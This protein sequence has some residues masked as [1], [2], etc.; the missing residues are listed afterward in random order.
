MSK[1]RRIPFLDVKGLTEDER[2]KLLGQKVIQEGLTV[3]FVVE[4]NA[5]ADRYMAKLKVIFPAI[6]EEARFKMTAD[7]ICVRVKS[8]LAKN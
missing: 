3:G 2:I 4:D 8:S 7:T 6:V 5:K 1:R